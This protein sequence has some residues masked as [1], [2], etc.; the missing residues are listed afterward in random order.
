MKKFSCP[1]AFYETT[2]GRSQACVVVD[3]VK[4][5][6]EV[7]D[8]HCQS[9]RVLNGIGGDDEVELIGHVVEQ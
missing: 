1:A 9:I 2:A 4:E 3:S 8:A 7:H 6:T 5:K